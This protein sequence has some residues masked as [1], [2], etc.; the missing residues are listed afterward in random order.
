M[1]EQCAYASTHQQTR[2]AIVAAAIIAVV[3]TA[4]DAGVRTN[5]LA[6]IAVVTHVIGARLVAAIVTVTIVAAAMIAVVAVAITAVALVFER[7]VAGHG[8]MRVRICMEGR[9]STGWH[10]E[11]EA[12]SGNGHG[13]GLEKFRHGFFLFSSNGRRGAPAMSLSFKGVNLNGMQRRSQ[14]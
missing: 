3:V 12:R 6:V 5:G 10:G 4:P 2:G 1:T 8:S 7:H 13:G 9:C 11:C 14:I